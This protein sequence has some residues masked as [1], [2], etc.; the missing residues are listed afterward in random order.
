MILLF[1]NWKGTPIITFYHAWS[2]DDPTPPLSYNF[3]LGETTK[4]GNTFLHMLFLDIGQG[5]YLLNSI[6]LKR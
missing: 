4:E 3:A 6:Y 5:F 1:P 2:S